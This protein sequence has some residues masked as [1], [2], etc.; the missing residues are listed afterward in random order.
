VAEVE[1]VEISGGGEVHAPGVGA[2]V[3]VGVGQ[4]REHASCVLSLGAVDKGNQEAEISHGLKLNG[5]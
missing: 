5:R 4:Q 3:G 1:G 2:Q